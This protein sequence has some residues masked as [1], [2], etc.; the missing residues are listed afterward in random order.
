MTKSRRTG[1]GSA[2]RRGRSGKKSAKRKNVFLGL[3]SRALMLIA[4]ALLMVS[5]LGVVVN[6]AK[7]WALVL[8]GVFFL[9]LFLLNLFLFI[10]ALF[11]RSKAAFIPLVALLP[12]LLLIGRLVRLPGNQEAQEESGDNLVVASYNVGRFAP[13]DRKRGIH[14][15]SECLDSVATLLGRTDADI[16]CLQEFYLSYNE[17]VSTVLSRAFP[18][19]YQTYY[20]YSGK[21]GL[22]GNVTLSRSRPVD[23]GHLEFENSSNLAV[24]ADYKVGNDTLRVYNCH[25]ESYNISLSSIIKAMHEGQ[26]VISE[27]GRKVRGSILRRPVQVGQI[28]AHISDCRNGSIVCG[29]FNDSPISYTYYKLH[30]GRRDSFVEAGSGF[31]ATYRPLWP[32]IRIDYLMH[33]KSMTA[34]SHETL[35][36]RYSDHYPII[37]TLCQH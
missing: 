26:D 1:K 12:A 17:D 24:Y 32:I 3:T 11:R 28:I 20:L 31:G 36:V 9:P 35:H 33:P 10:W 14:T 30:Q 6:P 37:V 29:D 15:R 13:T 19:Y 18:G 34:L 21:T 27:T 23:K 16:I 5:Y 8:P 25:L 2:A 7:A 4:A 22:Y